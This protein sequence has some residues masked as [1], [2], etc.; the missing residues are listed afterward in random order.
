MSTKSRSA[1]TL[2][3]LLVVIAIIGTL[4][5][6]LLPA[7]QAAREAARRATCNN[8]QKQLALALISYSTGGKG[9]FPGWA[10]SQKIQNGSVVQVIPISWA[11]KILPQID[12]QT[13][14][15][16]LLDGSMAF[17]APPR[18]E[19]LIC[20]SDASINPKLGT[21]TYVVNAGMPD[22]LQHPLPAAYVSSDI[23]ANGVC[24]DLRDGRKGT[25]NKDIKDG[26]S[27]T[28]LT[29]ENV[30]KDTDVAG[31]PCTWLGPLQTTLLSNPGTDSANNSDMDTNPEQRFGMV[32]RYISGSHL[33]PDKYAIQPFNRDFDPNDSSDTPGP[34]TSFGSRFARPASEHPEVFVVSFCGGNTREINEN[35]DFRVYQQLMTP[36]GQKIAEADAPNYLIE[37]NLSNAERFMVPPLNDADY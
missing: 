31:R 17:D 33:N 12:Q 27:S 32:W 21:L 20:P 8:N 34:Y 16:Q 23:P 19:V 14:R 10:H 11:A 3:E 4:V 15:D 37:K 5:G 22:P 30:H 26:A 25:A 36:D 13:L 2:V 6:L 18:I 9:S 1:F 24:M 35:I 28:L 7:V 29:S